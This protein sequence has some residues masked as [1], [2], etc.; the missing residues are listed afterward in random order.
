MSIVAERLA[1][2]MGESLNTGLSLQAS[3]RGIVGDPSLLISETLDILSEACGIFKAASEESLLLSIDLEYCSAARKKANNII[4]DISRIARKELGYS[5]KCTSRKGGHVYG[6]FVAPITPP[7]G[8]TDHDDLA[9][10][11]REIKPTPVF[12]EQPSLHDL[13][14]MISTLIGIHGIDDV[15]QTCISALN[16]AKEVA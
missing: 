11:I 16:E 7:K 15:G 10:R 2:E 3:I 8:I 13:S 12:H 4:N 6:S 9:A 1:T 14:T 5:I